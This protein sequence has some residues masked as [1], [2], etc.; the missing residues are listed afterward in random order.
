MYY[1]CDISSLQLKYGDLLC[2]SNEAFAGLIMKQNDDII[3]KNT[4]AKC[5]VNMSFSKNAIKSFAKIECL[6]V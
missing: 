5:L 3:R 2:T 4:V 1:I 6:L